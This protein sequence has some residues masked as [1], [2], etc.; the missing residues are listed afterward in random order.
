MCCSRTHIE[1]LQR[2]HI[3]NEKCWRNKK[4]VEVKKAARLMK[5]GKNERFFDFVYL[6]I[7]KETLEK[8]T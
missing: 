5:N 2:T 8:F 1:K 3:C 4:K 7:K 6:I